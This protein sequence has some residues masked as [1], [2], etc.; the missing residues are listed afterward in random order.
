MT[1][2]AAKNKFISPQP[3]A[4]WALDANDD[5]QAPVTIQQI[6]EQKSLLNLFLGNEENLRKMDCNR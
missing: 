6:Q 3:H 1:Y 2:D 4:S 5:W